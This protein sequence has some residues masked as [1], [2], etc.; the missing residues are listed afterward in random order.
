MERFVR[1]TCGRPEARIPWVP[2]ARD[3]ASTLRTLIDIGRSLVDVLPQ[4]AEGLGFA[5]ALLAAC[6]KDGKLPESRRADLRMLAQVLEQG[7]S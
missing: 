6:G 7:L 5:S 1:E 3:D 2:G 4:A